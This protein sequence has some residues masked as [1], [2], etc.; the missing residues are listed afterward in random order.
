MSTVAS[1]GSAAPPART[2]YAQLEA[3]ARR[4][5]AGLWS[6]PGQTEPWRGR[7]QHQD[8]GFVR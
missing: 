7:S 1:A 3:E 2:D 6:V 4:Q 5:G 8:R